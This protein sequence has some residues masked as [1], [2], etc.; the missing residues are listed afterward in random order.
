MCV[1]HSAGV[2]ENLPLAIF[3]FIRTE[4]VFVWIRTGCVSGVLACLILSFC[5]VYV[6][7]C[8]HYLPQLMHSYLWKKYLT[9]GKQKEKFS[10]F[11]ILLKTK[12]RLFAWNSKFRDSFS[13]SFNIKINALTYCSDSKQFTVYLQSIL[14]QGFPMPKTTSTTF[15]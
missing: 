13:F 11:L 3:I 9:P 5:R 6:C 14:L 2:G 4:G 10:L 7:V 12:T 8:V 15:P 1:S